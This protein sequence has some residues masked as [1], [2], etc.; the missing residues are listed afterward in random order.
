[1][2]SNIANYLKYNYFW[3]GVGINNVPS[4]FCSRHTVGVAGDNFMFHIVVIIVVVIVVVIV[5]IV[6][7]IVIVI[8]I[9]IIVS[10]IIIIIIIIIIVVINIVHIIITF[11]KVIIGSNT[12]IPYSKSDRIRIFR[13]PTNC[14][15][16]MNGISMLMCQ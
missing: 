11:V 1:M 12:F 15:K 7:V 16:G 5:I 6:I 13:E 4:N 8:D 2:I 14:I 9:D 3:D 10:I